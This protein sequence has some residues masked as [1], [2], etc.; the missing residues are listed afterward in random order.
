MLCNSGQ[1]EFGY[2]TTEAL[3]AQSKISKVEIR[4]SKFLC[5]LCVSVVNI[6]S[7]ETQMCQLNLAIRR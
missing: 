7:Q 1:K 4:K 5:E 6:S 3:R 2:L